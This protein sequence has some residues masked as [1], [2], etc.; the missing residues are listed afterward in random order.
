MIFFNLSFFRAYITSGASHGHGENDNSF[1]TFGLPQ[2]S[3]FQQ[4][5]ENNVTWINYFNS[6]FNPDAEFYTWTKTEN[7]TTTNV[8]HIAQFFSD[9][10]T[11]KLPQ[12]S[13]IN[14]EV[15]IYYLMPLFLSPM[16]LPCIDVLTISFLSINQCCSFSSMHPPSPI[17]LGEAWTKQIYEAVRGSP[18]WNNTLFIITFDEHGVCSK[19]SRI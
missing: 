19:V 15:R 6:S 3:I 9:A 14:P 8:K 13:Y 10:Q 4:L 17:N 16:S 7:K 1:S 2:R 11:G 5:S 12:F 18:Q